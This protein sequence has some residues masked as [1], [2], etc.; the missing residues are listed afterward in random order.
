[1]KD[2]DLTFSSSSSDDDEDFVGNR[3]AR[4]LKKSAKKPSSKRPR[5]KWKSRQ[6]SRLELSSSDDD[7]DDNSLLLLPSKSL[8]ENKLSP[9][10]PKSLSIRRSPSSRSRLTGKKSLYSCGSLSDSCSSD[11][12]F[13]L[14]NTQSL[15]RMLERKNRNA[16]ASAEKRKTSFCCDNQNEESASTIGAKI[17]R[18]NYDMCTRED[19]ATREYNSDAN[20]SDSDDTAELLRQL[21]GKPTLRDKID[22][23]KPSPASEIHLPRES[24]DQE[25]YADEKSLKD[26]DNDG[27]LLME[28]TEIATNSNSKRPAQGLPKDDCASPKT[29]SFSELNNEDDNTNNPNG[30]ELPPQSSSSEESS[31]YS[32]DDESSGDETEEKIRAPTNRKNPFENPKSSHRSMELNDGENEKHIQEWEKNKEMTPRQENQRIGFGHFW[33]KTNQE[34]FEV[35]FGDSNNNDYSKKSQNQRHQEHQ[36]LCIDLVDSDDDEKETSGKVYENE[37]STNSPRKRKSPMFNIASRNFIHKNP[38]KNPY[39]D[40]NAFGTRQEEVEDV[41]Q[42]EDDDPLLK[43]RPRRVTQDHANQIS[44]YNHNS[45]D[46]SHAASQEEQPPVQQDYQHSSGVNGIPRPWASSNSFASRRARRIRDPAASNL[47]LA[48]SVVVKPSTLSSRTRSNLATQSAVASIR[49]PQQQRN[50]ANNGDIRNFLSRRPGLA[51]ETRNRTRSIE[52]VRASRHDI[53]GHS[54]VTVVN[55]PARARSQRQRGGEQAEDAIEVFEDEEPKRPARKRKATTRKTKTTKRKRT[56]TRK[57]KSRKTGGRRRKKAA[58][59]RGRGGR[60]GSRSVTSNDDSG[61]WGS[62]TGGW[63]SA[64]PVHK[65]DP[66]FRNVGA[67][68]AF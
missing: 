27:K 62:T 14:S 42:F 46:A 17:H 57:T 64:R 48:S 20:G 32:D 56:T 5:P 65:E 35:A 68:I 54:N 55:P 52:T 2:E 49:G 40:S 63:S 60:F 29:E 25:S 16:I 24:V 10:S 45:G 9:K 30:F 3:K 11:E 12:S 28:D 33:T 58:G 67:E 38:Y 51:F 66:A 50:D 31:E 4:I 34:L 47:S 41:I 59:G 1:M 23:T 44:N 7:D 18:D 53:Q 26:V 13:V 61:A 39:R 22:T 37:E 19:D 43:T 8:K 36:Q 21:S 6:S 15:T